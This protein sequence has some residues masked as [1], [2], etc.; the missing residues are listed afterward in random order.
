MLEI[1]L[2]DC[3][4]PIFCSSAG[5]SSAMDSERA[6]EYSETERW[7]RWCGDEVV[8]RTR[9]D[10]SGLCEEVSS[11]WGRCFEDAWWGGCKSVEEE[12]WGW[13]LLLLLVFSLLLLFV[14]LLL[15]L[16]TIT[17]ER[18]NCWGGEEKDA[19]D[20]WLCRKMFE[21]VT[22]RRTFMLAPTVVVGEWRILCCGGR[23]RR[24]RGE[25]GN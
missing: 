9:S 6:K 19:D 15:L 1:F 17:G 23:S 3:S 2:S 22:E 7:Q 10:A 11:R 21:V 4:T 13:V 8:A 14:L 5:F 20:R 24:E 12:N 18:G 25:N 16:F